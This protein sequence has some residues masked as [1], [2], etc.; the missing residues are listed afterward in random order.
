MFLSIL[1]FGKILNFNGAR[2]GIDGE[3]EA[4]SGSCPLYGGNAWSEEAKLRFLEAVQS[5]P[6]DQFTDDNA[7][8]VDYVMSEL[9]NTCFM[10]ARRSLR[11][12][13]MVRAIKATRPMISHFRIYR[14][15]V[16]LQ[17]CLKFDTSKCGVLATTENPTNRFDARPVMYST[18]CPA[19]TALSRMAEECNVNLKAIL[20]AGLAL[21]PSDALTAPDQQ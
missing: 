11:K 7:M 6:S 20:S 12:R 1:L 13:N 2:P 8:V 14:V 3:A 5:R 4:A 10:T 17:G 16:W 18:L 21:C 15:A 19:H 9:E